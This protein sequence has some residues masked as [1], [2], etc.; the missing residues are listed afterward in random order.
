[1]YSYSLNEAATIS[2]LIR[3]FAEQRARA[4]IDLEHAEASGDWSGAQVARITIKRVSAEREAM[5][6]ALAL[7]LAQTQ[8]RRSATAH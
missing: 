2:Y 3:I 7:V 8:A 6:T 5:T 4:D 1:M